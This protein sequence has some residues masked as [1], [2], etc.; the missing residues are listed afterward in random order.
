MTEAGG[1]ASG[2]NTLFTST[3]TILTFTIGWL[4]V[5]VVAS[6]LYLGICWIAR[7]IHRA[8]DGADQDSKTTGPL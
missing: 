3:K 1:S 5:S 2:P 8:D 4:V 6:A 7:A